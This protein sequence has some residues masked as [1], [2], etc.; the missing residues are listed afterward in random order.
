MSKLPEYDAPSRRLC[1]EMRILMTS[2]RG[3]GHFGPLRVFA[4][5]FRADGHRVLVAIP[6]DAVDLVHRAGH[7]AWPLPEPNTDERDAV[8]ARTRGASEDEANAIVIGELFAGVYAR[9]TLPGVF[10]AVAE[11][12][13]D[14]IAHES[15]EYAGP[16]AAERAAVPAVHVAVGVGSFG[17]PV[18][19]WAAPH[20]DALRREHGLAPDPDGARLYDRPMLSLMPPS[21]DGGG[22]AHHFRAEH[23]EPR[24]WEGVY[25]SLGSVAPTSGMFPG[26]YRAAIE[27]LP[28]PLLVSTGGQDPE[29]LGPLPEGVRAERWVDEPVKADAMV[30]HG[31]AGSVR[32]A[33]AAGVPLVVMPLF[34]DQPHNARVVEQAGAGI[35][36]DGPGGVGEAVRTLLSEPRYGRRAR[37]IADEVAALPPARE[38]IA[39][40]PQV[41]DSTSPAARS[42]ENTAPFR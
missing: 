6:K 3:A 21:L 30:S 24:R 15:S 13:P 16:L 26:L 37:E 22:P 42:P 39:V 38:A 5:A 11:F 4:D 7:D 2:T 32:T 14:V 31:G 34:G 23:A 17:G 1:T 12:L 8:F 41:A 9:A 27:Q 40:L 35:V 20:V 10:G 25:L 18:I 28:T 36:A 19:G 29:A 33:L